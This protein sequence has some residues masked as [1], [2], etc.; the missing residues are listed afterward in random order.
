[1]FDFLAAASN[2]AGPK[3]ALDRAR[4]AVENKLGKFMSSRAR[5]IALRDAT[6]NPALVERANTL[7]R[8]INEIQTNAFEVMGEAAEIKENMAEGMTLA[9]VKS[10]AEVGKHLLEI[11]AA[12]DAHMGKADALAFEVSG[13]PKAQGKNFLETVKAVDRRVW[14]LASLAAIGAYLYFRKNR[15]GRR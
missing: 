3:D 7:L 4:A 13:S 12:M 1:M 6:T 10:A 2:V 9:D 14:V 8:E 5:V 11:N 15:R